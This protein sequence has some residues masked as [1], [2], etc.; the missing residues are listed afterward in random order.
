MQ[1]VEKACGVPGGGWARVDVVG[2]RL[3]RGSGK[4]EYFDLYAK[5]SS[6]LTFGVFG[7]S[8][9]GYRRRSRLM[10]KMLGGVRM[11]G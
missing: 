6:P 11:A 8:P 3:R 1:A 4:H 9:H 2:D 7:G 5:I 10:R